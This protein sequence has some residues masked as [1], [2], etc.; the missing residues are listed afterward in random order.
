MVFTIERKLALKQSE[1]KFAGEKKGP[2]DRKSKVENPSVLAKRVDLN[3]VAKNL[4]K[5]NFSP[6]FKL[7]KIYYIPTIL[8][9]GIAQVVR[10]QHS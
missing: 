6:H 3:P 2:F 1:D 8:Y 9:G 4:S 7:I 10:A 5:K